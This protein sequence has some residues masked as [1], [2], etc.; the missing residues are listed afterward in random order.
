MLILLRCSDGDA[1]ARFWRCSVSGPW[2]LFRVSGLI[3][4][5]HDKEPEKGRCFRAL[6][7]LGF[8]VGV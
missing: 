6:V 1:L 4:R 3:Y 2:D 5:S 8:R 7:G